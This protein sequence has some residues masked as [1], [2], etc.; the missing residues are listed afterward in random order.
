MV[1]G[2]L[3]KPD[4][5]LNTILV[6][7]TVA[8]IG[9]AIVAADIALSLAAHFQI[10]VTIAI[11]VEIVVVTMVV[12]VLSDMSPKVVAL[13]YPVP[14]ASLAAVP[15]T[16]LSI[17]FRP[18]T[19]GLEWLNS[20]VRGMAKPFK[21]TGNLSSD[22]IRRLGDVGEEDGTL[23]AMESTLLRNMSAL[24]ETTVKHVMVSRVDMVAA[25]VATPLDEILS[26]FHRSKL[27][28]LPMYEE[29]IDNIVGVLYAK[30]V[31]KYAGG[32]S[33]TTISARELLQPPLFVPES[34]SVHDLLQELRTARRHIAIALDEYGGVAGVVTIK[35][36]LQELI[37]EP[38][39]IILPPLDRESGSTGG[40]IV[41]E[42][43]T[44]I[45][46]VSELLGIDFDDTGGF[47]TIGGLVLSLA[48]SL[49]EVNQEFSCHGLVFKVLTI[50]KRRIEFLQVRREEGTALTPD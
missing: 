31:L 24:G 41:L 43:S 14:V 25:D 5:L 26:L 45:N 17:L 1:A 33:G 47:T 12:M 11:F 13:R 50:R 46:D 48:D 38:P 18:I 40:T 36:I 16:L 42:G 32:G 2:L 30:D 44:S 23:H 49:P 28:R 37:N 34:K 27:S 15:V 39:D 8:N 35:D 9:A 10:S 21:P 19:F 3:S 7:S 29:T 4:R 6:G 22:E 20:L